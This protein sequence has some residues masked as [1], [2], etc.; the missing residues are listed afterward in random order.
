MNRAKEEAMGPSQ[1][2]ALLI[3]T[4]L[5]ASNLGKWVPSNW[6]M[7]PHCSLLLP[8]FDMVA[9]SNKKG[10]R[11]LKPKEQEKEELLCWEC[12]HMEF[13]NDCCEETGQNWRRKPVEEIG[14]GRCQQLSAIEWVLHQDWDTWVLVDFLPLI[15]HVRNLRIA[16]YVIFLFIKSR[17]WNRKCL[18]ALTVH[19][20]HPFSDM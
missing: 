15:R 14:H 13:D 11:R 16:L 4:W 5:V 7:A 20:S 9:T 19:D 10:W 17:K 1:H 3:W 18:A 8:W 12:F 2:K 6:C